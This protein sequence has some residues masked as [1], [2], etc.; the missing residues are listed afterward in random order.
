MLDTYDYRQAMRLCNIALPLQQW[1]LQRAS[2]LRYTYTACLVLIMY[3][4][5]S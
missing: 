5:P 4:M 2:K 1:L 3:H